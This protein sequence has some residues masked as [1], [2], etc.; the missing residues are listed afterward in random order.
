MMANVKLLSVDAE[1]YEMAK[2]DR[3]VEAAKEALSGAVVNV[4]EDGRQSA[5]LFDFDAAV[6][7]WGEVH[8]SL[9]QKLFV[10]GRGALLDVEQLADEELEA[11][12][13]ILDREQARRA[14]AK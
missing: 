7:A 8:P 11:V 5:G 10:W 6:S 14:E 12:K 2:A 3:G 13:R 9:D 4:L 1:A